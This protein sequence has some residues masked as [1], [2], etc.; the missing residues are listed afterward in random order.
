MGGGYNKISMWVLHPW[1]LFASF[2]PLL[3]NWI[4]IA[5]LKFENNRKHVSFSACSNSVR[6]E[7]SLIS[8][9]PVKKLML[10]EVK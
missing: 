2:I 1:V 9:L 8:I 7:D 3:N 5:F 4:R 10:R 6:L